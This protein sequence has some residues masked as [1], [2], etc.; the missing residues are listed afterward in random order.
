VLAAVEVGKLF[1][2][3]YVSLIAGVGIT[4]V[5]SVIVY[6]GARAG[7]AARDQRRGEATLFFVVSVV[8]L[9]AFLVGLVVGVTIMLGK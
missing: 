7:E 2:V 3:V 8:A 5:F 4:A 6:S 9:V 1:E